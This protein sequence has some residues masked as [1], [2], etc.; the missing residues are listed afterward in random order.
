MYGEMADEKGEK[1]PERKSKSENH[2]EME[3]L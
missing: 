1:P 2:N 3:L